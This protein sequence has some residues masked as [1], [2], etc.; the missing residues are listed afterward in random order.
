MKYLWRPRIAIATTQEQCNEGYR[1]YEEE[2][3]RANKSST[4]RNG[5]RS[6]ASKNG[7]ERSSSEESGDENLGK[8]KL[9][10][11]KSQ[12]TNSTVI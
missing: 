4:S 9:P 6:R 11:V 7:A 10:R 8:A 5:R 2:S 12:I 1:A 3:R